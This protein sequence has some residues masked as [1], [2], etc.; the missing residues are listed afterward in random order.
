MSRL[1]AQKGLQFWD[2]S[3]HGE[4]IPGGAN[5]LGNLEE[6]IEKS[7]VV[8]VV[9]SQH[10]IENP[11]TRAE[12]AHATSRNIRIIPVHMSGVGDRGVGDRLPDPYDRLGQQRWYELAPDED[13]DVED[14]VS[15]ICAD[16]GAR[17]EPP[18]SRDPRFPLIQRFRGE[19]E[20]N[21]PRHEER[22]VSVRARL[23][24]VLVEFQLAYEGRELE[25]A[26]FLVSYLLAICQ[27]EFPH[28]AFYYPYLARAVCALDRD[29]V[30]LA[31]ATLAVIA[32][33]PLR[34]ESYWGLLGR[35]RYHQGL[36]RE[37]QECFRRAIAR[38]PQD[39]G[40]LAWAL[41]ATL[42]SGDT[43]EAGS[44]IDRLQTSRTYS[45]DERRKTDK[46]AALATAEVGQLED[47]ERRL[48]AHLAAWGP[49]ADVLVRLARLLLQTSRPHVAQ[50]DL[51]CQRHLFCHHA[52]FLQALAEVSWRAGALASA[53]ECYEQLAEQ[54]PKHRTLVLDAAQFH[55]LNGNVARGQ[56]LAARLLLT[57]EPAATA[58]EYYLDGLAN[59]ILERRERGNYD[60]ERSQRPAKD[61]YACWLP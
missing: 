1:K 45:D 8:V 14:K 29:D 58:Q 60:F 55:L 28:V 51:E 13:L 33:H 20:S 27:Y 59:W 54:F 40:G 46:L 52:A 23:D 38:D 15:R 26:D 37:A 36:Y 39:S 22:F 56:Q 3:E 49:D 9:V 50:R 16:V 57:V 47:A 35:I 30:A 2:Y 24:Q 19:V 41:N 44:L 34:D 42:A 31:L 25:R 21:I 17:Y 53:C 4:E 48:R 61:H 7:D 6:R 43:G 11:H 18:P 12:V 10:A 5:L 32:E